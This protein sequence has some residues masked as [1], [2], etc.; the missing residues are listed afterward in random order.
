MSS[1]TY[2]VKVDG[3]PLGQFG[4]ES[5]ARSFL[6]QLKAEGRKARI[7]ITFLGEKTVKK[8]DAP[9]AAEKPKKEAP[10]RTSKPK[11]A[12]K[13]K[14]RI[15]KGSK[16]EKLDVQTINRYCDRLKVRY[17]IAEEDGHYLISINGQVVD[18]LAESGLV[19]ENRPYARHDF[20]NLY[21]TPNPDGT[22]T[23]GSIFTR[24][25]YSYE[26]VCRKIEEYVDKANIH[27][28][29]ETKRL[30]EGKRRKEQEQ[31][32]HSGRY[33]TIDE[34]A[35]KRAKESYSFS[36]YTQG[37]ATARYR[38]R[39]DAFYDVVDKAKAQADPRFHRELDGCADSYARILAD[40]TNS[41]NSTQ[42]R[43]VSPMI[44]GR[45][46]FNQK[47]HN[48][49][50]GAVVNKHDDYTAKLKAIE[51]RVEY[52][53]RSGRTDFL[54]RSDEQD[55]VGMLKDKLARLEAYREL[56]KD[57]NAYRRKHGDMKGWG[58]E[59]E[60]PEEQSV[61]YSYPRGFEHWA[62]DYNNRK[63]KST[64]ERIEKLEKA[65]SAG[66]SQEQH[67]GFRVVRDPALMRILILFDDVPGEEIRDVLKRNGFRYARTDHSWRVHLSDNG[68][69]SLKKVI[70]EIEPQKSQNRRRRV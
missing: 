64:K 69:A 41:I 13:P 12:T 22:Y 66:G 23:A 60:I 44:A 26:D 35:A 27:E 42:A 19:G 11:P 31:A 46:G 20:Y 55:A 37:E 15:T 25:T 28:I 56:I 65:K 1:K 18:R 70:S 21:I 6:K 59:N 48:K 49:V 62:S 34:D 33:Y 16:S 39:V 43:T 63:I 58:R 57:G 30:E 2:T 17:V 67:D 4:S 9:K 51:D 3:K 8:K 40:M 36:H 61:D 29:E 68:E 7:H 10:K 24:E 53:S 54:I 14:G 38:E 52:L 5:K 45:S 50:M 47:K 32:E